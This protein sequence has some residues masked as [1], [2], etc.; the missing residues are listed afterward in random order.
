MA[1]GW[2]EWTQGF[3]FGAAVLQFDATGDRALPGTRP[4][5]HARADGVAPDA[6]RRARPRL[7]QRQHLR[8]PLAPGG[9]RTL[10]GQRVGASLLRAGAEG[11][12]RRAGPA[13]DA[14]ARWRLHPLVQRPALAVRGHDP[15]AAVAGPRSSARPSP[16]RGA[17]RA[18]QPARP[19]GP[20]RQGH[21]R[22]QRL[23]R[24]AGATPTTC[25]DARRT[26]RSSTPSTARSAGPTA[27]RATRPSARGP[28]GWPGRCSALPSSSSSSRRSATTTD[29]R[30]SEPSVDGRKRRPRSNG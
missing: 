15:L 29:R 8:Q 21:G 9:R 28:A 1:R 24:R 3:Q 14:A 20:A 30:D 7:Q 25:A 6:R 11:Q 23:L 16:E 4:H 12:R 22:L 18:G 19:A 2:T 17:G 10:R 5:P 26:R 27:S 13:L